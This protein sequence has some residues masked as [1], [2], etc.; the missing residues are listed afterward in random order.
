[1]F[2]SLKKH[3]ASS[4]PRREFEKRGGVLAHR[5]SGQPTWSERLLWTEGWSV[6]CARWR[7]SKCRK[8]CLDV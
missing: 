5:T 2:D 3:F 8:G 7:T 1:M 4:D 6:A